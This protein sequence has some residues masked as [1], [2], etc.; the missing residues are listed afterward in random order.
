[1]TI[2]YALLSVSDKT[3]IVDFWLNGLIECKGCDY[4][5][6]IEEIY[7]Q[8]IASQVAIHYFVGN[9]YQSRNLAEQPD[10]PKLI[11]T[12][13]KYCKFFQFEVNGL[14]YYTGGP[15]EGAEQPIEQPDS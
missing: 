15:I 4:G 11:A 3:G 6:F 14:H 8:E 5:K 12:F 10:I 2:Q 7:D 1:M 9:D 13:N